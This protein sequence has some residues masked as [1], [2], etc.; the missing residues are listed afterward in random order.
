MVPIFATFVHGEGAPPFF[1]G[2]SQVGCVFL[3][4]PMLGGAET[5]VLKAKG[6]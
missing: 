3:G 5:S 1:G 2:F 6:V 4:D